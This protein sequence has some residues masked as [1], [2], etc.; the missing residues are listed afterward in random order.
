MQRRQLLQALF[1]VAALPMVPAACGRAPKTPLAH[2][3]GQQWVHGAYQQYAQTY[4]DLQSSAEQKTTD[5]YA[6]L[7]QKGIVALDGLQSREVPFFIQVTGN[8]QEYRI[9]RDVPERLKF[10]A[11]MSEA[12]RQ[13]ATEAWKTAREFIHTDYA[14]IARLNWA[15]TSLLQQL[16]SIRTGIDE[17]HIE[18]Y[19]LTRQVTELK[20]G[21]LPFELP[22]QVTAAD[23]E[24]VLLLLLERLEDDRARL[25][26]VESSIVAVGLTTRATDAG[27]GSLASNI[28]AVLVAVVEEASQSQPR[29]A[30]FPADSDTHDGALARG[31]ALY[32][33]IATSEPYQVWLREERNRELQQLGTL[34]S[35]LDSVTGLPTSAIYQQAVNLWTGKADYLSYLELAARLVPGS[36]AVASVLKKGVDTTRKVRKVAGTLDKLKDG[37]LALPDV[38]QLQ[39]LNTGSKFARARLARQLT[40]FEHPEEIALAEKA[41]AETSLMHSKLRDVSN[42]SRPH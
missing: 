9:H 2:L 22:Y 3:Y 30:E 20:E 42:A 28:R 27:S 17:G 15:L 6:M 39:L 1:G 4:L 34:L 41:L 38:P 21:T 35:I 40:F 29:P 31:R 23:Y 33:K 13:A 25:E 32:G 8:G 16:Q 26:R 37:K 5:A 7:A 18:Q 14:E 36:G 10:T 24:R 11:D 19:R 12:D